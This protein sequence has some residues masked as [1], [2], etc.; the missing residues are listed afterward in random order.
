MRDKQLVCI[1][2]VIVT[3]H[4]TCPHLPCPSSKSIRP[5]TAKQS[6]C[7]NQRV[8]ILVTDKLNRQLFT[9]RL[10]ATCKKILG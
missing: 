7:F 8:V 9:L 1:I 3:T 10:E 2:Y 6:N 4:D 5:H